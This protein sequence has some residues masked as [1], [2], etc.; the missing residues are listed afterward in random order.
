MS[1]PSAGRPADPEDLKIITLARSARARTSAA[2]GRLRPRHRRADV[3][4][5]QRG[6]CRTWQ[7]SALA[8]AVAMAV[9]SGAPGLEAAALVGDEDPRRTMTWRCSATCPVPTV[10]VWR[11]DGSGR[12][13]RGHAVTDPE[14]SPELVAERGLRQARTA[15]SRR[16]PFRVRLLRRPAQR[17]QVDADQRPGR[18]QGRDRLLQAADHPARDPRHRA[19]ARRPAGADR[20]PGSAQ[21]ADPA[22]GAAQRPGPDHLVRGRRGRGLPAGQRADRA[23]RRLP[24]RRDRGAAD[25]DPS[26]V[27]IA[28]KSDLVTPGRMAEHLTGSP[29]WRS[30]S[31][32]AGR[33]SSRCPRPQHDQIDLLADLLVSLLP[34]GSAALPGR[35]GHRRAGP[36]P[37]SPS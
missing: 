20:H 17:G 35:R 33:T 1:A 18:Q 21:A 16:L 26:S 29:R 14:G 15:S 28:T 11:A 9:S 31:A 37:W 32:S 6:T 4:G 34:R 23:G 2:A 8:V 5:R 22:G 25:A 10:A 13:S 24:G 30:S 36:R 27:A 3:R 12:C 19:P 7:L